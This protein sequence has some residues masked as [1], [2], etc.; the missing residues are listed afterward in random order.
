MN[1]N[2]RRTTP[3][4]GFT[5]TLVLILLDMVLLLSTIVLS[6]IHPLMNVYRMFFQSSMKEQGEDYLSSVDLIK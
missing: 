4:K 6:A 2:G 1:N 5:S 3:G